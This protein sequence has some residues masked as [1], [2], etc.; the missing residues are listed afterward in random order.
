MARGIPFDALADCI[1]RLDKVAKDGSSRGTLEFIGDF[2]EMGDGK[3]GIAGRAALSE[4]L[5]KFVELEPVELRGDIVRLREW[6]L[7][8][9]L[10]LYWEFGHARIETKSS[11]G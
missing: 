7:E 1:A 9:G 3:W 4:E 2:A 6:V 11:G 10:K 8:R 5:A